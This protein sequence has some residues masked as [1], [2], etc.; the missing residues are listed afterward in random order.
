MVTADA[1][2]T[3]A[4]RAVSVRRACILASASHLEQIRA[5]DRSLHQ[6]RHST[7]AW[8]GND[9]SYSVRYTFKTHIKLLGVIRD[10]LSSQCRTLESIDEVARFRLISLRMSIAVMLRARD[11]Q[12][13]SIL[14]YVPT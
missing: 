13:G 9:S 2:Q 5:T 11:G 8:I 4:P 12:M 3:A 10:G 6:S 14:Y 7:R 1:E